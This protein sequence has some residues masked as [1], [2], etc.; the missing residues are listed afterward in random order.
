MSNE[1]LRECPFCGKTEPLMIEHIPE[2]RAEYEAYVVRCNAKEGGCGANGGHSLGRD[3]AIEKWNTRSIN[4]P[5][6]ETVSELHRFIV[7]WKFPTDLQNREFYV[8]CKDEEEAKNIFEYSHHNNALLL[9]VCD[10]VRVF[11]TTESHGKP[12]IKE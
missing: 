8:E 1:K 2:T 9:G 5:K 6:H 10:M 11:A 7:S 4:T 12:E 3:G